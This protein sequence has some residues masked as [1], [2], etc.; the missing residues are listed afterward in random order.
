M[1]NVP[2][3]CVI[4]RMYGLRSYLLQGNNKKITDGIGNVIYSQPAA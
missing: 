3:N 1:G 2:I 4:F